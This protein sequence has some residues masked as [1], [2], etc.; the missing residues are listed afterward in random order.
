M[1][2]NQL[3]SFLAVVELG[4][5]RAAADRLVV[6][7]PAVSGAVAALARDL[8]VDLV[9]RHGRGLR[10][11]PAG[12]AF[13]DAV[14]SGLG[15][16]DRG[17]RVARSVEEPGR[18]SV[19][20]ASIVTAAERL[21]IPLLAAFRAAH[22]QAAVAVQVGNRAAVWEALRDL[23]ADL[24]VAGRPPTSTAATVLGRATNTLAVV[25]GPEM[26]GRSRRDT[27]VLLA[28]TTWLLREEGS[29][30]RDAT[31]ELLARLGLD[32]PRMILGSNGAVTEAVVA[33]FG[34]GLLPLGALETR[35]APGALARID[36]PGTP[37]ERPWHLVASSE[38][39]LSPTATLAARSLLAEPDGFAPTP[40][41]RRVLRP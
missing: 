6:S 16:L 23:D 38:V 41:G 18:G 27:T 15:H 5:V 17:V 37:I 40:E 13:A 8:G 2:L 36:C 22:P 12:I 20:I 34:I 7:Q 33:G 3:R 30:T 1:T 19:R 26:A 31:E 24:V 29:G 35:L 11:T 14:R 10:I 9:Q 25:G 32:P 21:V 4:S 39:A 28:T